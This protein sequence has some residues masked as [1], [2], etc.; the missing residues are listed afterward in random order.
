MRTLWTPA[1]SWARRWSDPPFAK[2]SVI[3]HILPKYLLTI[4]FLSSCYRVLPRLP[5]SPGSR[6]FNHSTFVLWF[7]LVKSS[8]PRIFL[9]KTGK[10]F[11]QSAVQCSTLGLLFL[12]I[13][14]FFGNAWKTSYFSLD[15]PWDY[16]IMV[17]RIANERRLVL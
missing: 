11:V 4:S 13:H 8:I 17:Q 2:H 9:C 6:F 5:C 7:F 15:F 10:N 12:L 3:G 1:A 14:Q 16:C